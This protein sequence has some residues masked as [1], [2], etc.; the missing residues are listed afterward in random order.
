MEAKKRL[1]DLCLKRKKRKKNKISQRL[2]MLVMQIRMGPIMVVMVVVVMMMMKMMMKEIT[3]LIVPNKLILSVT[4]DSAL[5]CSVV[6][7]T[8]DV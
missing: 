3:S 5:F 7:T 4:L 6:P 2:L 8:N 1:E